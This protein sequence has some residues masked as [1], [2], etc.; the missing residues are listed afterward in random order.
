MELLR[1]QTAIVTSWA[2]LTGRGLPLLGTN[3]RRESQLLGTRSASQ[4]GPPGHNRPLLACVHVDNVFFDP[5]LESRDIDGGGW[6]E[7]LAAANAELREVP[8]AFDDVSIDVAV[9]ERRFVV[10]AP[11]TSREVLTIHVE[12]RDRRVRRNC[13]GLSGRNLADLAGGYP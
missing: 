10:G 3:R 6:A 2:L 8:R 9:G 4:A 11:V 7:Q 13:D 1:G 5:Y 12:Y